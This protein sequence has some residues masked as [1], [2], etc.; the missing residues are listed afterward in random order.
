LQ[1]SAQGAVAQIA[2]ICETTGVVARKNEICEVLNERLICW[3]GFE[4]IALGCVERP[5]GQGE[6]TERRF[7]RFLKAKTLFAGKSGEGFVPVAGRLF[8]GTK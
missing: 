8:E 5:A 2:K 4:G 1:A 7:L 6:L 3:L